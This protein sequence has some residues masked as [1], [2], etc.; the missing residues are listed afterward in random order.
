M[1]A[2]LLDDTIGYETLNWVG[3]DINNIDVRL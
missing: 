2:V 1:R 3:A